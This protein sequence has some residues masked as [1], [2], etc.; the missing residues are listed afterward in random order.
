M[1][2]QEITAFI[3]EMNRQGDVDWTPEAVAKVY[4]SDSLEF[5]LNDHMATIERFGA[6]ID[7]VLNK[8]AK[9]FIVIPP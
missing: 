4:G 1:T 9:R 3:A 6:I 7:A 8:D 2:Q 5:A